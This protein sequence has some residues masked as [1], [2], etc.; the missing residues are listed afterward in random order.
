[1]RDKFE[2]I[3]A[4]LFPASQSAIGDWASF[5]WHRDRHGKIDAHKAHSS[6]ALA[7][8]VFGAIKVSP[9]RDQILAAIARKCGLPDDGPWTLELEWAAPHK[10]LGEPTPTQVDAVA[11]GRNAVLVIECKFT[12]VGGR[13]SQPVVTK[14]G[15]R[16]CNRSYTMQRNPV[17]GKT[18][19]C[20]LI[21]KGVQYWKFI[22]TAFR[23]D[24]DR[25]Y[26]PCPFNGEAYQWMRNAVLAEALASAHGVAG[27]VVAAY[28]DADK[29]STAVKVRTGYFQ[30]PDLSFRRLFP[31]TYQSIIA[32]ARSHSDNQ[33]LWDE[34]GAWVERKIGNVEAALCEAAAVRAVRRLVPTVPQ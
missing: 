18:D 19:R 25:D 27:A 34:L 23:L 21:P 33:C 1:M 11:F 4:N 22:P 32:L 10:L 26:S 30:Q 8:D 6:Q 20:A 15:E 24:A 16:Q 17:N 13:C 9:D 3:K 14:T 29:F 7:I 28:A 2:A 12:E 5:R 31:M